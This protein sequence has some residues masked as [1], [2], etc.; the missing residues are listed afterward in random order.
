MWRVIN[1]QAIKDIPQEAPA[2][3]HLKSSR[4]TS[5]GYGGE[6]ASRNHGCK[7]ICIFMCGWFFKVH[8]GQIYFKKSDKCDVFKMV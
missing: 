7:N 2:S 3:Y 6:Y 4:G 8:L 1:G 5:H